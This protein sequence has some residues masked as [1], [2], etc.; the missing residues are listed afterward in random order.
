MRPRVLAAEAPASVVWSSLWIKRADA[1][2]CFD[3]PLR[4]DGGTD[5]QWTLPVAE[6][7]PDD[8]FVGHMRKRL[9]ELINANPRYTFGQ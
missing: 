6:P 2:I 7:T 1:T 3:L 8:G 4:G 9:N 5:L